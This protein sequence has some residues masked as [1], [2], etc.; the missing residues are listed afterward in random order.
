MAISGITT[1]IFSTIENPKSVLPIILKDGV[2]SAC[3]TYKAFKAGG[4]VEGIDR[5]TDE[6]GTQA[7]WIGGIPFFKKLIDKTI[8]KAAKIN[9]DVDIRIIGNEEYASWAVKNAKGVMNGAKQT[10]SEALD[11]AL[12]NP[13]K[14]K[15]L[16]GA[17]VALA[18]AL[19]LFTY[20]K[21]T[22]ARHKN[23]ENIINNE[24]N[25]EKAF[26]AKFDGKDI[27]DNK[28]SVTSN[29][30][31]MKSPKNSF[32]GLGTMGTK[33]VEGVLFNPVHNM[34]IIDAGI[35]T[36]R[37]AAAR[38]KTEFFETAIK[39][40]SFLFFVYGFGNLIQKGI[41]KLSASKFKTPIDL[42][43]N[44]ITSPELKQAM[45]EGV[46]TAQTGALEGA[47]EGLTKT[48]DFIVKNPKNI[49]VQAAKKTGLVSTLK[50]GDTVDVTKFIDVK[51]V[52]S[53]KDSL[54]TFNSAMKSSGLGVDEFLS[55]AKKLKS[56]SIVANI[57]LSCLVLGYGIPKAVYEYRKWKT[58]STS[59][60]VAND[61]KNKNANI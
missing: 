44:V 32:K 29:L 43:Y 58:G 54:D 40:G 12:K 24:I 13:V 34:K 7:I 15:A 25:K 48:L 26:A 16:Y 42:N 60:H 5:G 6:F 19:T 36:E 20:F 4:A 1:K 10:V 8:Y 35:T 3:V 50:G 57:V 51:E 18:T 9:P 39:E 23:T 61:I 55:K 49:L 2:D 45:K 53:L 22:H 27:A 33:V 28:I 21:L 37:L 56:L 52:K 41:N 30:A 31:F 46:L 11:T 59:F 47:G 14:S 17:K 38:N